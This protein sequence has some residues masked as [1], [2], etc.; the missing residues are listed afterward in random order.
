MKNRIMK[1][2]IN[3]KEVKMHR[4][5]EQPVI[6]MAIFFICTFIF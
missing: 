4:K 3:K 5:I 1:A 6:N 2:N